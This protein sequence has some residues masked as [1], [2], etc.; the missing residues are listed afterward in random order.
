MSTPMIGIL[1]GMGPHSTAPFVDLLVDQCQRQYGARE[2]A[3][4]APMLIYS[5][6]TPFHADRPIDHG[7]ME[8]AL[9]A[10]LAVL[11]RAGADF[12]AI[13]CNSAHVYHAQLA[14][15]ARVP[16]LNM[17]ELTVAALPATTGSVA[18]VG[19]RSTLDSGMYQAAI[20]A[21]GFACADP[22]WQD[23]VDAILAMLR[24]A[25]AGSTLDAAWQ[26]LASRIAAAGA[27]T[28]VMA[29]ADLSALKLPLEAT[30][31]DATDCLAREAIAQWHARM[32]AGSSINEDGSHG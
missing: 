13:A 9:H 19:A 15:R 18:V 23:Q 25:P 4:F 10:G 26:S 11:E 6:P 32:L 14:R 12:M 20:A 27:E 16:L 2:D 24:G 8:T 3:D 21:R 5:L 22:V 31:V 30:V 17:V 28:I 29:C 1:A 7:A